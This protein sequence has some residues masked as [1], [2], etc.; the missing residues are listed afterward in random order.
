MGVGSAP[1][2]G[3]GEGDAAGVSVGAGGVGVGTCAREAVTQ[4][5]AQAAIMAA[6]QSERELTR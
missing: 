4:S 5:E 2:T 6:P 3:A 1:G